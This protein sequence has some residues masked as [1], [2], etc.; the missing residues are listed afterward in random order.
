MERLRLIG[1]IF[2]FSSFRYGVRSGSVDGGINK[3][4]KQIRGEG[5]ETANIIRVG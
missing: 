5:C 1:I 3:F 2:G 4:I